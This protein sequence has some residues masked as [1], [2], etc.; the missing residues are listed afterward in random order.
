M[1][2]LPGKVVQFV[3]KLRWI[4]VLGAGMV[5]HPNVLKMSGVDPEEYGGF[6]FWNRTTRSFWLGWKYG[7]LTIF[8]T[9]TKMMS[10]SLNQFDQKG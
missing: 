1:F 9:S 6:G 10:A 8:V 4:E 2:Q 5:S 7:K 3:N